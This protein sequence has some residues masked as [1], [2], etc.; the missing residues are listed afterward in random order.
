MN[1]VFLGPSGSGKDTQAEILVDAF[2]YQ[3]VSTGDILRDI[4]FGE[5]DIHRYIK[6]SMNQGFLDDELVFGLLKV[7]LQN[8]GIENVILSGVVRKQSQI[9]LLD[10]IL[11]KINQKVDMAVYFELSDEEALDR[12]MGRL[13]CK[14]CKANFH[15]K[16]NPP[17]IEGVCDNCGEDL[18]KRDDDNEESIKRRLADFHKD[19]EAIVAIYQERGVLFKLD[20]SK[21]IGDIQKELLEMLPKSDL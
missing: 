11:G 6:E 3:R 4:S 5:R 8:K 10:T 1:L 21:S 15:R 13:Y 17:E 7:Y 9:L 12:M 18:S 14:L 19:N 16:F 2:N 20:A